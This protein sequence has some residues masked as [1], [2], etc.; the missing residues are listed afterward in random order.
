MKLLITLLC[1]L[2]LLAGTDSDIIEIE[3]KDSVVSLNIN[4]QNY[5]FDIPELAVGESEIISTESG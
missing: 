4:N 2:L 5:D 1:S 3:L